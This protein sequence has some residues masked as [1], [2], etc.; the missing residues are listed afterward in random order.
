LPGGSASVDLDGTSWT[1]IALNGKDLIPETEI[2]LTVDGDQLSGTAGCNRYF[3][4]VTFEDGTPSVGMLGSTE[5][6]CG[7]PEGVMEQETGY[8]QALGSVARYTVENKELTLFDAEGQALL[9]FVTETESSDEGNIVDS[10]NAVET[11]TEK[12]DVIVD[13]IDLLVMESF[14]VQV[15]AIVRGNLSNGCVVLDGVSVKRT[16]QGFLIEVETHVEGDFCTQAQVPFEERVSLDVLGLPA[17]TYTVRAGEVSADLTF[18]V[19]N[20]PADDRTSAGSPSDAPAEYVQDLRGTV[21]GIEIGADGLQVELTV[22]LAQRDE[23]TY[24][25]TISVMQAEVFGRW[26]GIQQGAELVVSGPVVAGMTPT[27]V[28]A[29]KV[30]V[31]ES[32]SDYVS[33]LHGTV[34]RVE[35][36]PVGLRAEIRADDGTDYRVTFDPATTEIVYLGGETEIQVG[37]PVL[38]SGELFRLMEAQFAP[39][40]A[41]DVTVVL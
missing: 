29:E 40:I 6:W 27:L 14:P 35:T 31:V 22:P 19:D 12:T 16:D 17:G 26:E 18:D 20:G 10:G 1:L 34:T 41:A 7:A 3:G 24:S 36:G 13:G 2:T 28:V 8:L 25:V 38:V 30:I 33:N 37:T 32:G 21:T 9:V 5:M 11:G 15:E 4:S 39:R 23:S